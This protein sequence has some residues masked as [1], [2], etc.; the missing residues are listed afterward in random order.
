M[1]SA[2]R[3]FIVSSYGRYN[4]RHNDGKLFFN[5]YYSANI[6]DVQYGDIVIGIKSKK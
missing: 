6:K 5:S 4:S 1:M 3:F 2:F